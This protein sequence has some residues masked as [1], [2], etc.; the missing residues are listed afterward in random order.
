[1]NQPVTNLV[2]LI[3]V[4]EHV[5]GGAEFQVYELI[6]NLDKTRFHVHLFILHQ[7]DIPEEIS[8]LPIEVKAL[9]I[10]RIYDISGF[11]A[12]VKFLN[13]LKKHKTDILMTYHFSSDI[14]GALWGKL[15]GTPVI[16]SNRRDTGFWKKRGHIWAYKMINPLISKI[17][18]V[19]QS[20]K[21]IVMEQENV[22]E[23]KI[24]V[25]YNGIDIQK[26]NRIDFSEVQNEFKGKAKT[27][28]L[29]VGNFRPIKGHIYLIE[30]F[31]N[32]ARKNADVVLL[33]AGKGEDQ[34]ILSQK[35]A[36]LGIEEKVCFLGQRKDIP[37]LIA[38]SD[39]CVLPSLSEGFSNALLEYMMCGKPVVATKVGGNPE[40]VENGVNGLLVPPNDACAIERAIQTFLDQPELARQAGLNAKN[41]VEKNFDLKKQILAMSDFLVNSR[42]PKSGDSKKKVFHLISSNGI[43][44]A[45]KVMLA[46]GSHM[47]KNQWKVIIGALN[48]KNNPHLEVLKEAQTMGMET[49]V[50]DC[51]GR[52]DFKA[53][54]RLS[55]LLRESEIDLIHTHNYKSDLMGVLASLKTKIPVVCTNHGW[56]HSGF[57][58]NAYESMDAF[59]MKFFMRKIFA[60][61][62]GMQVEI[63]KKR[64]PSSKIQF[65][66]N[67]IF[68]ED[69]ISH[70]NQKKEFGIDPSVL[71]FGVIGRLSIEK[72]HK[73]LFEALSRLRPS[74]EKIQFL[75]VGEGPL[76]CT[77]ERFV[78]DLNI[79]SFVQFTGYQKDITR[80][81]NSIDILVQPSLKEGLPISLL[82]AMSFAKPIIATHVG[83][84]SDLIHDKSTGILIPPGSSEE[85]YNAMRLLI[86]DP[87]LREQLGQ[88]AREYVKLNYSLE[89]MVQAYAEQ[90]RQILTVIGNNNGLMK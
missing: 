85:I 52:V 63:I 50:I 18:V 26:F 73:F 45:E 17:I 68:I 12:G 13:N 58:L 82:E 2:I 35:A 24:T 66:P 34:K 71:V 21:Q 14:W 5:H 90:Y 16:I 57:L 15:A 59:F 44:G 27:L 25:I 62:K 81:F 38:S 87:M 83:D 33:L 31:E 72:G 1:M 64:V 74:P 76:R 9:G 42:Y 77:L 37:A 70:V 51:S 28:I 19:S 39:I 20:V 60:V 48:N 75:I 61:S 3:D 78:S 53:V 7:N 69:A 56:I 10:N 43:Y 11:M 36:E 8:R 55:S 32:I 89:K 29:C 41:T 30:A 40:I 67:G 49:A 22:P 79:S 84:V 6:K 86:E 4:L 65:I 80:V 46:L 47:D 23:I 54:R 88:N